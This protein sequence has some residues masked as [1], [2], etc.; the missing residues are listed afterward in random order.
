[1]SDSTEAPG[2]KGP[3]P[4]GEAAWKAAKENVAARNAEARKVAR[5]QRQADDAAAAQGRA[6]AHRREMDGLI[7]KPA[8]R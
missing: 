8:R 4:R 3:S 2:V 1:M 6:D 7:E 5:R